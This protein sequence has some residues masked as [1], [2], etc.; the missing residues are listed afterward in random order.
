MQTNHLKLTTIYCAY[1]GNRV[2]GLCFFQLIVHAYNVVFVVTHS[3]D[4]KL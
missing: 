2:N 4:S 1:I 3:M